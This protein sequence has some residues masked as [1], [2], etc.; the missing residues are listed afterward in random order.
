MT[1]H[2][3]TNINTNLTEYDIQCVDTEDEID[4]VESLL[5]DFT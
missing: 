2:S 4:F 3:I 1:P 5:Y